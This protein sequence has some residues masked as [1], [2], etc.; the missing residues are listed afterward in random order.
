MTNGAYLTI[1]RLNTF[2]YLPNESTKA[3]LD[4]IKKM[5]YEDIPGTIIEKKEFTAP[6]QGISILNKTKKGDYQKYH[7]YKTPLEIIVVK[8]GGKKDFVLQ[9]EAEIFNSIKLKPHSNKYS[10]FND[11]FN[12]YS[13][14]FPENF[15]TE[16]TKI[17]GKKM[18]QG[19]LDDNYYFFQESPHYDVEY[20]EEDQFEAQYIHTNFYKDLKLEET[21]GA[22][23]NGQYKSYVSSAIIDSLNHK[24]IWLKSVVKD[25]SYYL[26]G[27]FGDNEKKAT[28]YFN[29]LKFNDFKYETLKKEIDTSLHFTVKSPVKAPLHFDRYQLN[30]KKAF[31]ENIKN[32]FYRTKA[33]EQIF[34]KRTK[35]HDLQMFENVDS[36]WNSINKKREFLRG[37]QTSTNEKLESFDEKRFN[38]N[39]M[40]IL[41]HKLKDTTSSKIILVKYFQKQGVL[42]KLSTL[43]DSI[44]KASNFINEFYNSFTPRDTLLGK[45]IFK[46]KSKQFFE[47]LKHNDS[48]VLTG[49]SKLKLSKK[50]SLL[51]IDALENYEFPEEKE[52]I[53]NYL[54]RTL[55]ENDTSKNVTDFIT[56]LY[57]KSYSNPIL[58]RIILNTIFDRHNKESYSLL[59]K[60]METDLPLGSK[61][62]NFKIYSSKVDS[63]K[64]A[65]LLFP[66]LLNFS[67]VEEYKPAIYALLTRLKDSN[68]VKTKIYKS[69]KKQI[70]SDAKIQIKRS[71]AKNKNRYYSYNKDFTL[72]NY[73]KLLFPFRDDKAV[74]TFYL[75]LLESNDE[76]ALTTYFTLLKSEG[77]LIPEALKSK[78]LLNE[79]TQHLLISKLKTEKLLS[80]NITN[81]IDLKTFAKS[82]LFENS[83]YKDHE[84]NITFLEEKQFKTDTN[85]SIRLFVFK[86]K[87]KNQNDNDEY[88]HYIAFEDSKTDTYNTKPYDTSKRNGESVFGTKTNEELIDAFILLIKHKTRKRITEK[89]Y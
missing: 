46:D 50:H 55:I 14:S 69:Y 15:I 82:K 63:L 24:S 68:I 79:S 31:D 30:K 71:L 73:V 61:T 22:S 56:N 53:K 41:T 11:H 29:S 33:N 86:R 83:N 75:R 87:N 70:I 43:Q 40:N 16:N 4:Y 47:A 89:R 34:V 80:K 65:K 88:L 59:L 76:E 13:F 48:I 39:G 42:Y 10:R 6:Y 77:E 54:L 1:N 23:G 8:F 67:T 27:Y 38:E 72:D 5:L 2:E 28:S 12:K 85:K 21:S 51:I 18:I 62:P 49:Y 66:K 17:A 52:M 20:I 3:D 7:I 32:T 44:G 64:T 36:L 45:D 35:F 19:H 84:N 26:L 60:L 74:K 81:I 57:L 58:Q 25:E 78:T 9:H 37:I